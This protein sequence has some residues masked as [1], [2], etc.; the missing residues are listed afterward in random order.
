MLRG[1]KTVINKMKK[2]SLLILG[3][4]ILMLVTGGVGYASTWKGEELM[5]TWREAAWK[6]GPFRIQ[7]VLMLRNAGYDSNV[8]QSTNPIKDFSFTA[9]PAFNIYLPIKSK[10]LFQIYE[11]PQYVYFKETARERTWNNYFRGEVHFLFNKWLFSASLGLSNAREKWNTEID[12]RP[13][14]KEESFQGSF[15]WQASRKTSFSI[16]YKKAKYDYES[17]EYERFN[18]KEQLNREENYLNFVGY[19]QLS[20]RMRMFVDGEYG[21]FSFDNPSSLRDSR[22]Y[23]VYTGFEFSPLGKIRGR[24]HLGYKFFDSLA[25]ESQDYKGIVG[26]TNVQVRLLWP[27]SIRAMYRRD[28]Q[29][30]LWYNNTYFLENKA[31]G[32]ASF[33]VFK[34]K[35]R[36]D[37][38]YSLGINSYPESSKQV[39]VR[40]EDNYEEHSVGIYFRLKENIGI[41]MTAGRWKREI[42]ISKEKSERGFVGLNLTYDF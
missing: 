33:Y 3:M 10:I 1:W 22:S 42:N 8:Y 35:V 9:G 40:R 28:I 32:G 11:S 15:L 36:L 41:G 39:T 6:F 20:S 26:D 2:I 17:I 31:G 37:Y 29:F 34:R 19:Y 24:I 25:P 14:R 38:D 5:R 23:G 12:I 21:V 30:S 4:I 27:L 16:S 7:P 18:V 13:R